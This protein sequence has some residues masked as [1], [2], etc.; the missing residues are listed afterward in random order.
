[1][2]DN[3]ITVSKTDVGK[4]DWVYERIVDNGTVKA[5]LACVLPVVEP[6]RVFL[7]RTSDTIRN[8]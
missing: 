6:V 1:V 2:P 7:V 3:D 8:S 5:S 4:S